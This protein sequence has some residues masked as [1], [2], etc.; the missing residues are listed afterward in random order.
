VCEEVLE[1]AGIDLGLV[2]RRTQT[3]NSRQLREVIGILRH[4][5]AVP[6]SWPHGGVGGA[7][8]PGNILFPVHR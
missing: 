4:H 5:H 8:V 3:D 7:H 2:S 1:D 6:N